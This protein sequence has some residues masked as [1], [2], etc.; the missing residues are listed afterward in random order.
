[1]GE[2]EQ[3]ESFVR[4]LS[5]FLKSEAGEDGLEYTHDSVLIVDAWNCVFRNAGIKGTD[6]EH[7]IYA[8]ASL[9]HLDED[10]RCVPDDKK[11]RRLARVYF[12]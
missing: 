11:L 2:P 1:M 6:E 3:I 4:S 10:L 8:M 12:K 9:C 7:D 5:A